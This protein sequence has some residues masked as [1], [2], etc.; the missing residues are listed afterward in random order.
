MNLIFLLSY[1]D[2]DPRH[3]VPWDRTGP[4]STRHRSTS[5]RVRVRGGRNTREVGEGW[6][7]DE[8]L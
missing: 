4:H 2:T 3:S 1:R 6:A 5:P 7:H 8:G